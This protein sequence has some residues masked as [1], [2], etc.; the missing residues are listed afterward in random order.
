MRLPRNWLFLFFE[1]WVVDIR[2]S[3]IIIG[4]E[5]HLEVCWQIIQ[6]EFTM[7]IAF[8]LT[9][10]FVCLRPF[11]R[12]LASICDCSCFPHASWASRKRSWIIA[13]HFGST[14][15]VSSSSIVCLTEGCLIL[16]MLSQVFIIDV[17]VQLTWDFSYCTR[18][19]TWHKSRA[20]ISLQQLLWGRTKVVIRWFPWSMCIFSWLRILSRES[21]MWGPLLSIIFTILSTASACLASC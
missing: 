16:R 20:A 1:D 10:H 19:S 13:K 9:L 18:E 6:L 12:R 15:L 7:S 3:V 4:R 5:G 17:A 21:M 14:C 2:W 8:I 11:S